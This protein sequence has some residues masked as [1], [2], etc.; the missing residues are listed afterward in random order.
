MS[1]R[2]DNMPPNDHVLELLADRTLDEVSP[3]D[4]AELDRWLNA[5]TED[6]SMDLAAGAAL[7]AMLGKAQPAPAS[8]MTRAA[9]TAE[10]YQRELA[11]G[12]FRLGTPSLRL[13]ESD[14][15]I[16]QP[17]RVGAAWLGWLA[18]AACLAFAAIGWLPAFRARQTPQLTAA[19][20]LAGLRAE[21]D[22]AKDA[23]RSPWADWD[24]PEIA[25]VKGEIVWSQSKQKGY[26]VFRGLPKNDPA[27]EQYQLWIVDDRGIEHRVSGGIFNA[28]TSTA[29]TADGSGWRGQVRCEMIGDDLYVEVEPRINVRQPALFA[30]TIE[31]PGGTWLSNMKRRV[32]VAQPT[33]G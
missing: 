12:S 21:V 29:L 4:Q 17:R 19:V 15:P 9:Q 23:T 33:K 18:A 6:E 26:M 22:S 32:C 16:P 30:V 14:A 5:N 8:V 28:P 1:S 7:L 31:E 27:R 11:N 10:L 2:L 24:K 25:G 20:S 3:Q 13:T